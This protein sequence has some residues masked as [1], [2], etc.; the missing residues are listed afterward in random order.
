MS[1]TVLDL[2]ALVPPT[3]TIKFG[4]K[5][6]VVQP[7]KTGDLLRLGSLGKKIEDIADAPTEEVDALIV[8][9]T[10]L[11]Q[12]IIPELDGVD[13]NTQQLLGLVSLIGQMATPPETKEL[14]SKGITA[15]GGN[16]DP[17][18]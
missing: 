10:K 12:K 6:I 8:D 14:E 18:A 15:A 16:T 9:L 5:E 1:N 2:D 17:K 13:L 4:G 7:P 3:A 11:V